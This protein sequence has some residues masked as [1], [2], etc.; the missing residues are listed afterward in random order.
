MSSEAERRELYTRWHT[1][2]EADRA[3]VWTEMH[4]RGI[5]GSPHEPPRNDPRQLEIEMRRDSIEWL[6]MMAEYGPDDCRPTFA[7]IAEELRT[8]RQQNATL[9]L[10]VERIAGLPV[11]GHEPTDEPGE[12]FARAAE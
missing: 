8:L 6:E 7:R 3:A 9:T 12:L 10:A 2:P 4:Q 11:S 5:V 1:C